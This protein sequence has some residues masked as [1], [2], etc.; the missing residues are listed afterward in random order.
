MTAS[1]AKGSGAGAGGGV[2]LPLSDASEVVVGN[3]VAGE[4]SSV[5]LKFSIIWLPLCAR[6]HVGTSAHDERR[7]IAGGERWCRC[8]AL[9]RCARCTVR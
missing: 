2:P 1:E 6:A 8:C 3:G 9:S 4:L 5:S 7:M